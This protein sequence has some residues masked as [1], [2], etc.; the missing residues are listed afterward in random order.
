MLHIKRRYTDC[1]VGWFVDICIGHCHLCVNFHVQPVKPHS[2][3][4]QMG[5]RLRSKDCSDD[6]YHIPRVRAGAMPTASA[7]SCSWRSSRRADFR[8]SHPVLAYSS[9][10]TAASRD[11]KA[12]GPTRE[13]IERGCACS[14][15]TG[16][17]ERVEITFAPGRI[18][19]R[20]RPLIVSYS[21]PRRIVLPSVR[22]K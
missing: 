22:S 16:G 11:G 2:T 8:R 21:S 13:S 17:E 1:P 10:L 6:Q 7:A 4:V 12:P 5:R 3:L 18:V 9:V 14:K 15:G 19:S 20:S